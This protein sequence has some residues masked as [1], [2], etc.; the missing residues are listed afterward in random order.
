M[1]AAM[2]RRLANGGD[3]CVIAVAVALLAAPVALLANDMPQPWPVA[4]GIV[5]T[6]LTATAAYAVIRQARRRRQ[7]RRTR[8]PLAKAADAIFV[9]AAL[10]M[11]AAPVA[12]YANDAMMEPWQWATAVLLI[13][14]VAGASAAILK[15]VHACDARRAALS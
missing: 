2:L 6:P 14:C 7:A 11:L 13:A 9:A 3:A 4:V 5:L 12:R 15:L 1:P 10:S 8:P